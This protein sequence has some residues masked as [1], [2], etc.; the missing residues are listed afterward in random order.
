[1]ARRGA[2]TGSST[3]PHEVRDPMSTRLKAIAD[4][5]GLD[6]S[7]LASA[8]ANVREIFGDDLATDPQFIGPV[9]AA[10]AQLIRFGSHDTVANY[11][12]KNI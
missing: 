10:L 11:F 9:T 5:E 2:R 8:L 12:R 4:R 6:A 7:R 3:A 1:M